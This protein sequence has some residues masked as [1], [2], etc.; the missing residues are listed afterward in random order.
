MCVCAGWDHDD[1]PYVCKLEYELQRCMAMACS[2]V[3][4]KSRFKKGYDQPGKTK[5]SNVIF[6]NKT[7]HDEF[8]LKT[9]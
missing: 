5:N 6:N 1:Y 7:S 2:P 8:A 9:I 4:P 3:A